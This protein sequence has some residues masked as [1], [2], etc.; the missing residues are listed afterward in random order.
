MAITLSNIHFPSMTSF[1]HFFEG[2]LLLKIYLT[3]KNVKPI[4]LRDFHVFC[5]FGSS[6]Y[7]K[8]NWRSLLVCRTTPINS[9]ILFFLLLWH[10]ILCEN[11]WTPAVYLFY[12]FC[13]V[14]SLDIRVSLLETLLQQIGSFPLQQGGW[15]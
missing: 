7:T 4:Y 14:P 2:G 13:C 1:M 15:K 12:C 11:V 8:S 10:R 6:Q 5:K 3:R 9:F